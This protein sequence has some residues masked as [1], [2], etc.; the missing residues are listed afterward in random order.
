VNPQ[1][2]PV[3]G[4]CEKDRA[5]CVYPNPAKTSSDND[6]IDVVKLTPVQGAMVQRQKGEDRQM[7]FYSSA[8]RIDFSNLEVMLKEYHNIPGLKEGRARRIPVYVLIALSVNDYT[9][10]QNLRGTSPSNYFWSHWI[11]ESIASQDECVTLG[12]TRLLG[13]T[14]YTLPTGIGPKPRH[15]SGKGTPRITEPM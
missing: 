1:A 10:S 4:H 9:S 15:K 12:A 8:A 5:E 7:S 11:A 14:S 6:K 13:G 2:R 3:C